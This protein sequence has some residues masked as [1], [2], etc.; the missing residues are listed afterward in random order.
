MN[1][2]NDKSL[3]I[4]TIIIIALGILVSA[5][6]LF[7]TTGGQS[8]NMVNQFGDTVKIY[9]DG[10]YG[11]YFN[12]KFFKSMESNQGDYKGDTVVKSIS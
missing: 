2:S 11:I 7:Y 3:Y 8:F 12:I 5:V 9:G 6:G 4:L 1:K 10:L